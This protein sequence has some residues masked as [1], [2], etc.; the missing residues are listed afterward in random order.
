MFTSRSEYRLLLR[1]DNADQRI[2]PLGINIG[3]VSSERQNSF[4]NKMIKIKDGF[5]LAKSF[6][7]SPD[8]LLKKGIKIN[9][10]GKKRNIID[11]FSFSNITT[12]KLK[13][14]LPELAKLSK[15]V[16]EQIEIEAKYSG[17]LE[18]QRE[19]ILDFKK[20]ENL[21]IPK[22]INYKNVGSLSNEIIEKLSKIKPPTLGAASR[23]S[24]VTPPAVIAILR[25]IKKNKNKKAA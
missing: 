20:D 18:R 2:T 7:I 25:Y 1:S 10:D 24:G 9:K 17:Y 19:D 21:K 16:I 3:C 23:V 12:N 5:S 22:N 14:I 15:D 4:E 13:K 6:Q 11:L 8:A